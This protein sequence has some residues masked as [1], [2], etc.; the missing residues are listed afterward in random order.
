MDSRGS[1]YCGIYISAIAAPMDKPT[2]R[3]ICK[4]M[5]H[6]MVEGFE[7]WAAQITG[8]ASIIQSS[9]AART[10][11]IAFTKMM[12]SLVSQLL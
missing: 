4:G 9:L 3:N 7:D 12:I 8:N 1:S 2:C 5:G 10:A 11:G 6:M